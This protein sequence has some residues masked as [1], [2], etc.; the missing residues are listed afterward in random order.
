MGDASAEN[1]RDTVPARLEQF[2][3]RAFRRPATSAEVERYTSVIET[4]VKAGDSFEQGMQ[5]VLQGIL[6]SPHFLFRVEL[7]EMDS[8][9]QIAADQPAE[10]ADAEP[11][12]GLRVRQVGEYELA[13][14]FRRTSCGRACL[15][16][17]Y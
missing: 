15:T 4:V 2:V 8:P 3:G 1:W 7:D 13:S 14:R 12:D 5:L 11:A 9:S 10:G 6:I 16:M 17:S